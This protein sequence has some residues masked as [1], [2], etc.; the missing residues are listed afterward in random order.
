M[1]INGGCSR[2]GF[3]V[4]EGCLRLGLP[5]LSKRLPAWTGSRGRL[6]APGGGTWPRVVGGH[7]PQIPVFSAFSTVCKVPPSTP[8]RRSQGAG[9]RFGLLSG[10]FPPHVVGAI[11]GSVNFP[12]LTRE[13]GADS[14]FAAGRR[15]AAPACRPRARSRF[16]QGV[17]WGDC[18]TKGKPEKR[19]RPTGP[20]FRH[21]SARRPRRGSG[22]FLDPI[23]Q[24]AVCF[25]EGGEGLLRGWE[26]LRFGWAPG[27][28]KRLARKRNQGQGRHAGVFANS[29]GLGTRFQGPKG[30]RGPGRSPR[31]MRVSV[32]GRGPAGGPGRARS[33]LNFP[34]TPGAAQGPTGFW[35]IAAERLGGTLKQKKGQ[36]AQFERKW[37]PEC[38]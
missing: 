21:P 4:R 33:S 2:K 30:P 7:E 24:G 29:R 35:L 1:G 15:P 18:P 8:Q 13:T 27:A 31:S 25:G 38:G 32:Q 36:G 3:D 9:I 34:A 12:P 22:I 37:P 10:Q 19:F 14:F 20:W 17:P 16:S 28:G 11:A 23:D 6:G 26:G 5:S